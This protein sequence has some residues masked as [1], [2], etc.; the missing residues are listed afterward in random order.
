[1]SKVET[2]LG[3]ITYQ[4]EH[5]EA[6]RAETSSAVGISERYFTKCRRDIRELSFH[7]SKPLMKRNE[8][9]LLMSKLNEDVQNERAVRR[10][11]QRAYPAAKDGTIEIASPQDRPSNQ[12]LR[13]GL[14]TPIG[15]RAYVGFWF[16]RLLYDPLLWKD[17]TGKTHYR[18][19][20]ACANME[21]Y[22][23]WRVRL[24]KDLHWSDGK[25]I[26]L[27]DIAHSVAKNRV[28][29]T[30]QEVKNI[31]KGEML[32]ILNM[33]DPLFPYKLS[34]VPI[35]PSYSPGYDTISG[36]F[37]LKES[38]QPNSFNL[39]RNEDYY[40]SN[41]PKIDRINITTFARY[42]FAI[43]AVRERELDIFPIRS[44]RHIY[45]WSSIIPQRFPCKDLSYYLLQINRETGLLSST[46]A[47]AQ[48]KASINY[49][50]LDLHFSPSAPKEIGTSFSPEKKSSLNM[51]YLSDMPDSLLGD[52]SLL[53]ASFLKADRHL[54]NV[55]NYPR[56]DVRAEMDVVLTQLYFGYGYSRLKRF[57]HSKGDDNILGFRHPEIDS[58]IEKLDK[59]A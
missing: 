16:E 33:N 45:R 11:L 20:S 54:I 42:P 10:K 50:A 44:L 28:A 24:K 52:L 14:E 58:L 22:S 39:I 36:P 13:I 38:R 59:T 41:H 25:P 30:I 49:N 3:I 23:K 27:K 5:P 12:Y 35:R 37:V 31:D 2:L 19:A 1:M 57:F 34:H 15:G 17:K 46:S 40:R 56:K 47:I 26:T 55:T 18:L 6:S 8:L 7:L 4:R 43:K 9:D 51:G 21:G 29:P 53:V 32:F 48:M